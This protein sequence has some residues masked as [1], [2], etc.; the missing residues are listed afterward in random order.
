MRGARGSPLS[1]PESWW[2]WLMVDYV[3]NDDD[4]C[5][6]GPAGERDSTYDYALVCD[7]DETSS[8]DANATGRLQSVGGSVKRRVR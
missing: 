5:A 1:L 8:C 2:W 6:P 3:D 4:D 7:C